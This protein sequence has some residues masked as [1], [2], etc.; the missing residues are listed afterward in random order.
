M[1]CRS[2]IRKASG[3]VYVSVGP[4]LRTVGKYI[5]ASAAVLKNPK[6]RSSCF[7]FRKE[8][9]WWCRSGT[10]LFRTKYPGQDR[11]PSHVRPQ[12]RNLPNIAVSIIQT[13]GRRSLS[14]GTSRKSADMPSYEMKCFIMTLVA[15]IYTGCLFITF[16]NFLKSDSRKRSSSK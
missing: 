10:Y 1:S 3:T 2:V 16:R 7:F 8:W 13:T 4:V 15:V 6:R 9:L 5:Q 12:R 11:V 14:N